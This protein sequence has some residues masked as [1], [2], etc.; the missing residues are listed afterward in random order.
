MKRW[1][2]KTIAGALVPVQVGN[3]RQIQDFQW[4]FDGK[5]RREL[6]LCFSYKNG[7]AYL[8]A[9][10]YEL[11]GHLYFKKIKKRTFS[12]IFTLRPILFLR[13][14]DVTEAQLDAIERDIEAREGTREISCIELLRLVLEEGGGIKMKH[15]EPRMI[16]L[17]Q[18]VS[19]FLQHGFVD[20]NTGRRVNY[21][22]YLTERWAWPEVMTFL[23][24]LEERFF[25]LGHSGIWTARILRWPGQMLR[26]LRQHFLG[27]RRRSVLH[28][29]S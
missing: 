13:F 21:E 28:Y 27:E 24:R 14:P 12:R 11:H 9:G 10:K 4:W 22:V 18:F 2:P 1:Q 19:S 25:W 26:R 20:A 15:F 16:Y 7:H 23:G 29:R 3:F 17:Q 5:T 8:V 6:L